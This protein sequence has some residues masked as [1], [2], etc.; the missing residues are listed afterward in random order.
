MAETFSKSV[1]TSIEPA[2]IHFKHYKG[3]WLSPVLLLALKWSASVSPTSSTVNN[4][5]GDSG[6][7]KKLSGGKVSSKNSS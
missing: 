4:K 7:V 1:N 2:P 3:I 5:S 6:G